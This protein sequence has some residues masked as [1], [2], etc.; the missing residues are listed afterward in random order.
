MPNVLT[1][2]SNEYE[3]VILN[4]TVHNPDQH[5]QAL[6]TIIAQ[7][8]K[9]IGLLIGAGGPA[10]MADVAGNYPL[11][12]AVEG[13]TTQVLAAMQPKYEAQITA[14]KAELTKHDIETILSRIRSF[15]GVLGASKVHDMDGAAFKNFGEEVCKHIGE[16]VNVRLPKG[17]RTAY[18]DIASWITGVIPT[19]DDHNPLAHLRCPMVIMRQ[20]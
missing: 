11:I 16:I 9:R 5:M 6:R 14:L 4:V 3:G 13:M 1:T 18:H 2:D 10:G 7:G 20:G 8:R 15:A 17:K 19:C 12:P